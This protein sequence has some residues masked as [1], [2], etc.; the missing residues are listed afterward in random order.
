[1]RAVAVVIQQRAAVRY[2]VDA[3]KVVY[4]A[5]SVVIDAIRPALADPL[6]TF[7]RIRPQ[8][9]EQVLVRDIHTRVDHRND[10]V[11]RARPDLP[12]LQRVDIG[13]RG[14]AGLSRIVQVPRLS[15]SGSSGGV[16]LSCRK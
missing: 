9:V 5:V 10:D 3:V 8:I 7:L 6:G 15:N 4:I 13:V 14:A 16:S 2:R 1:M 12:R 11:A